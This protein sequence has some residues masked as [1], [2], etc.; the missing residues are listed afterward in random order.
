MASSVA[1]LVQ[2]LGQAAANVDKAQKVALTA[3]LV[4]AKQRMLSAA[5]AVNTP[6]TI[7]TS[8]GKRGN[9]YSVRYL[10]FGN[11]DP[12]TATIFYTGAPP[13][14]RELGIQQHTI[15]PKRTRRGGERKGHL[16]L[17]AND[18][19]F[20]HADHPGVPA[21]PFWEPTQTQIAS[22][23]TVIYQKALHAA[24]ANALGHN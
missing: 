14:W 18:L 4:D 23:S 5:A 22:D 21:R 12:S 20:A 17:L 6:K 15:E 19:Y 16:A 10:W 1:D 24:L 13:Y 11:A 2:K 8:R 7:N 9:A 3:V